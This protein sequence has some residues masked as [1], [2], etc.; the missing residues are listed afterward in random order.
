M[1]K[2]HVQLTPQDRDT[3]TALNQGELLLSRCPHLNDLMN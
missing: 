3:L 1:P 2:Q